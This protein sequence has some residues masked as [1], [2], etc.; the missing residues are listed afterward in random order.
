MAHEGRGDIDQEKRGRPGLQTG[1]TE[2][3]RRHGLTASRL[4]GCCGRRLL[5]CVTSVDLPCITVKR[6]PGER[7]PGGERNECLSSVSIEDLIH[8][9]HPSV[10]PS[11]QP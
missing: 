11:V 2:S 3:P 9:V 8:P 1:N 6:M 5:Q 7:D 10:P 4:A